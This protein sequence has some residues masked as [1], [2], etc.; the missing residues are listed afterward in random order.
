M[1]MRSI[2][3]RALLPGLV[4]CTCFAAQAAQPTAKKPAPQV[5]LTP[6][7]LGAASSKAKPAAVPKTHQQSLATKRYV[8]GGI[9]SYQLSEDRMVNLVEVRSADGSAGPQAE[10]HRHGA[11]AVTAAEASE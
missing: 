4:L 5:R 10:M 11:P 7:V 6:F 1:R 8:R 2:A 9:V 3:G